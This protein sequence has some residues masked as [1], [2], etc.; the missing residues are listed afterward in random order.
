MTYIVIYLSSSISTKRLEEKLNLLVFF[1]EVNMH[2][3][4]KIEQAI[5]VKNISF[6]N[7]AE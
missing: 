1:L 3:L 5:H 4:N 6:C 7:D 2:L